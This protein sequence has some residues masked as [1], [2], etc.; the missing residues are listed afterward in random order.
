MPGSLDDAREE[1]IRRGVGAYERHIFLC[2]GPDC[3]SEEQ[4]LAAW[5]H[6]KS[7]VAE[8]NA[9]GARAYRTKV[10]CLRICTAGPVAVVYPEGTWYACLDHAALDRVVDEHLIDGR[11]VGDLVIGANPLPAPGE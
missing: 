2:T 3:C 9:R 1:A 11:P 4:G 5:T 7:R 6:L 8:A 10:G